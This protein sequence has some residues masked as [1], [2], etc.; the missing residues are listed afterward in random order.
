MLCRTVQRTP[1][2]CASVCIGFPGF[3]GFAHCA[4]GHKGSSDKA[5]DV[6]EGSDEGGDPCNFQV[7]SNKEVE[8]FA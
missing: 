1:K 6:I 3:I 2:C 4:E 7:V 5:M 8:H